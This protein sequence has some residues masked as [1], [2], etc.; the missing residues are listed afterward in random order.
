[1][2]AT[3]EPPPPAR[4]ENLRKWLFGEGDARRFTQ[5]SA[6][7]PRVWLDYAAAPESAHDLLL[8]PHSRSSSAALAR[9]L[10][11]RFERDGKQTTRLAYNESYV[12]AR[13]TLQDLVRDVVPLS[14]WW[15]KTIGR[16]PIEDVGAWV[17]QEREGLREELEDP[18]VPLEHCGSRGE[19]IWYVG[20]VGR[21]CDGDGADGGFDVDVVISKAAKLL[22]GVPAMPTDE[23]A[24]LWCVNPNRAART[25]LS[26]S[27]GAVKADAAA[28]L[29]DLDCS[30]LCWAIV[31]AG[32][33]ATHPA[34]GLRDADGEL[35]ESGSAVQSRVRC[36]LDFTRLRKLMAGELEAPQGSRRALRQLEQRL[37][38][39]HAIDWDALAPLLRVE[40]D[41]YEPPQGEH[42]THVA[43]IV[44]ADWRAGDADPAPYGQDLKG[45]CP[46]I[47]LYDL[48]V[49]ESPN[50][51]WEFPITAALQFVRHLNA[52]SDLQVIHGVNLSLSID[53]DVR[54]Y[55]CGRTPICDEC[56]RLVGSG[57]VVVAA[58]GNEGRAQYVSENG[59]TDGYRTT[60]IT[61]PGNADG[62]YD[63]RGDAPLLAPHLRRLLLLQPRADG[64][65]AQKARPRGARR[66]DPR[67]GARRR[68]EGQGR[69]EPGGAARERR[70]GAA[71]GAARGAPRPAAAHQ[72]GALLGGDRP[73]ARALLPGRRACSTSSA[74]SR[75]YD[76][77]F[78]LEALR[79][80]ARRQPRAP[81]RR[82]RRTA[83]HRDRR[84]PDRGL[85]DA[86]RPRL[87]ELAATWPNER[88]PAAVDVLMVSHMDD[89]HI[90]GVLDLSDDLI[91]R[92]TVTPSPWRSR[93]CGTTRSPTS[94]AETRAAVVVS[95]VRTAP[96]RSRPPAASRRRGAATRGRSWRACRRRGGCA[97]TPA[98]SAG[99]RT[100]SS[101]GS[102]RRRPR[103]AACSTS[104]R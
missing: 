101:T 78:T 27:R 24:V 69:H 42:G 102:S 58:A 15:S 26:R 95:T 91:A 32:I 104:V 13:L 47:V 48:R 57:V 41:R 93:R 96:V 79:A 9:A 34:F 29:F 87:D 22:A 103:A 60:S 56:N 21:V 37:K 72:G 64:R 45:I 1:M 83:L 89:D 39:G 11:A 18:A 71:D 6:V 38:L 8:T 16:R 63:G 68:R 66:A 3:S 100:R 40:H 81:L 54:N 70:R 10:N 99:S 73:R 49:F 80:Q 98:C 85:R 76:V 92:R 28:R 82:R 50:S 43:G 74:R 35:I 97:T 55:A 77:I 94:R 90:R 33:D 31:D 67:A 53:H 46:D 30:T 61:D 4:G 65:R 19:L 84:R 17:E 20:L 51:G 23:P 36:T 12:V 59:V 2:S 88:R 62:V 14:S 5:D 75:R 52:H 44:A 25:T 7:L 86:F